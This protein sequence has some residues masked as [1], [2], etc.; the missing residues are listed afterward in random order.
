MLGFFARTQLGSQL[1]SSFG[2]ESVHTQFLRF[3]GIA[4]PSNLCAIELEPWHPRSCINMELRRLRPPT[5]RVSRNILDALSMMGNSVLVSKASM[6]LGEF[7]TRYP[8]HFTCNTMRAYVQAYLRNLPWKQSVRRFVWELFDIR[9]DPDTLAGIESAR[10]K[11]AIRDFESGTQQSQDESGNLTSMSRIS[12]DFTTT[13]LEVSLQGEDR[14]NV[15]LFKRFACFD[16]SDEEEELAEDEEDTFASSS[17]RSELLDVDSERLDD[18][19]ENMADSKAAA[20]SEMKLLD[21][22]LGSSS[23]TY[24][25]PPLS[26]LPPASGL[27]KKKHHEERATKSPPLPPKRL[28]GGFN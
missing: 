20:K 3:K 21:T 24:F 11:I 17:P 6:R 26:S 4:I 13:G 7:R 12:P 8:L 9:L 25:P 5:G 23:T 27:R 16:D 28:V 22:N 2:W 15:D 18:K 1:L 14:P 10:S 19:A